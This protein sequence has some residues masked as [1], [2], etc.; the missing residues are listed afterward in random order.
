MYVT[1]NMNN[2][3]TKKNIFNA[4]F[5]T[6]WSASMEKNHNITKCSIEM[7]FEQFFEKYY[8]SFFVNYCKV[9][10]H[11]DNYEDLAEEAFIELWK[12]WDKLDSHA[13]FVLFVWVKNAVMLMSKSYHRKQAKEPKFIEFNEYV[14]DLFPHLNLD[15]NPSM[16]ERFAEDETYQYYL[17]EINKQLSPNDQQLFRCMIVNKMSIRETA[18][19]LSKS[20]K[21][22]S[23]AITRLRVR[24]RR[25]ILPEILPNTPLSKE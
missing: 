1:Y 5:Q 6:D 22:V 14:D 2:I 11:V 25:T 17:T 3:Y 23:V 15:L 21:A 9:H 20:E 24:L 7:T 19:H 18:A 16:E 10:L 12:H 13:E 8:F 4:S